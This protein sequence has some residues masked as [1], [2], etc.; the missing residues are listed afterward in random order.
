MDDDSQNAVTKK[1]IF[2]QKDQIHEYSEN[3]VQR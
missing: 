2:W 1:G 3:G